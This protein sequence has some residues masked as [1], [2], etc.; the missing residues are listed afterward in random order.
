M[1]KFFKSF[2]YAGCG[3]Y[4]TLHERN[5]RV[6]AVAAWIAI[7]LGIYFRISKLEWIIILFC[8]GMVM[9]AECF[10]S[11]IE[12]LSNVVRDDLGATY[13]RMGPCRDLAAG[14]VLILAIVA[15]IIGT[16]IFFPYFLTVFQ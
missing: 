2:V 11:A 5:M 13:A 9:A 6:H 8:I 16:I 3:I 14:A 7:L 1:Q 10:N 12:D 4:R 15:G